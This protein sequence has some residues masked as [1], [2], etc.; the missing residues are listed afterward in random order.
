M[1]WRAH[2]AEEAAIR[3]ERIAIARHL[4]GPPHRD[5]I[6]TRARTHTLNPS[7]QPRACEQPNNW[8]VLLF[9]PPVGLSWRS[10]HRRATRRWLRV[11]HG[12]AA[13]R[14]RGKDL[15]LHG[16]PAA[17]EQ[18]GHGTEL[19]SSP[20]Q[21]RNTRP[22]AEPM[23]D[24]CRPG[25]VSLSLGFSRTLC[26]L[27]LC[28]CVCVPAVGD[29]ARPPR[30]GAFFRGP[31]RSRRAEAKDRSCSQGRGG[32]ALPPRAL[33]RPQKVSG[34]VRGEGRQANR[35]SGC[36]CFGPL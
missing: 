8:M 7:A 16:A 20:W 9:F 2:E 27:R 6:A 30:R 10:P 36:A 11:R 29:G 32:R 21:H 15:R 22:A 26:V 18:P 33:G 3:R 5:C 4:A 1:E 12:A 34:L 23:P 35:T 24:L 25:P 13:A 17:E 14:Q 28:A 31:G 19:G